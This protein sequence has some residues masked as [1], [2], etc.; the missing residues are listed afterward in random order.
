MSGMFRA[1]TASILP[2]LFDDNH[3]PIA[4][5]SL[6]IIQPELGG[7]QTDKESAFQNTENRD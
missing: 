6:I 4:V 7:G 5:R 1:K 2:A 3:P